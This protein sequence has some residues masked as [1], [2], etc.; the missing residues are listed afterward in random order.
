[1]NNYK[2]NNCTCDIDFSEDDGYRY[3][4]DELKEIRTHADK[5]IDLLEKRIEK[6]KIIKEVLSTEYE[7]EE[8]KILKDD[9]DEELIKIHK[10]ILDD[11]IKK[12]NINTTLYPH[13]I[14]YTLNNLPYPYY[15]WY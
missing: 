9:T 7:D 6:D 12:N 5:T 11:L 1:M 8:E 10:K 4:L 2:C 3:I 13:R 14:M 15:T